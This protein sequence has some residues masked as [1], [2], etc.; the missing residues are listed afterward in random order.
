M[1]STLRAR[2]VAEQPF[3][4]LRYDPIAA[5]SH[6]VST[7]DQRDHCRRK[8]EEFVRVQDLNKLVHERV[9]EARVSHQGKLKAIT[10]DA[11]N[12]L[13]SEDILGC[14]FSKKKKSRF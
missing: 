4:L 2:G 8:V 3:L 9:E 1:A 12:P 13:F 14:E 7:R 5:Q 10:I 6:I 11:S